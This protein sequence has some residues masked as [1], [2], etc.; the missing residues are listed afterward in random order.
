MY[1]IMADQTE[2]FRHWLHKVIKKDKRIT[3]KKL[4]EL[5]KCDPSTISSYIRFRTRPD[6]AT[7]EIIKALLGATDQE[8]TEQ[9]EAEIAQKT[10]T[11]STA[12]EQPEANVLVLE[13]QKMIER[14]KDKSRGKYLN[15]LLLEIEELDPDALD[16]IADNLQNRLKYLRKKSSPTRPLKDGSSTS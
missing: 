2:I 16:E 13:H 6:Y 11:Q 9:G 8:V 3:G 14:F 5:A 10:T 1:K 15:T 7:Q 4:A 12:S